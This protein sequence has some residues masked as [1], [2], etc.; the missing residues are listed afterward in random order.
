MTVVGLLSLKCFPAVY[1]I[2]EFETYVLH[3][4]L[5]VHIQLRPALSAILATILFVSMLFKLVSI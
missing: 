5:Y 4:L 1:I 2:F 3:E